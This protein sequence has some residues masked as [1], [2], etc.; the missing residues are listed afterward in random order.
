MKKCSKCGEEK[1]LDAFY[2]HKGTRTSEGYL[3]PSCKACHNK[4]SIQWAKSNPEKVAEHRRKRN[5]KKK[6]GLSVEQYEKM[7]IEQNNSC[8][9]CGCVSLRRRLNVDHCHKTGAV[10]KL[11]CDKCNMAIGLLEDDT[12]RLEKARKYL[13]NFTT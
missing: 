9:I 8:Y 1:P 4:Q 5:L 6:Y 10:R 13:E 12:T 7:T 11:L 3:N 2:A